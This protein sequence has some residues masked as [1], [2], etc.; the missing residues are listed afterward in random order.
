MISLARVGILPGKKKVV[1]AIK[2]FIDKV[3]ARLENQGL[4][5]DSVIVFISVF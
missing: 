2:A 5:N 4:V 3:V 1:G